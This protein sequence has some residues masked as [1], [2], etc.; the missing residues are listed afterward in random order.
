MSMAGGAYKVY[1]VGSSLAERGFA[2]LRHRHLLL[3]LVASDLRSRYRRSYLGVAW[4]MV[5]PIA[6]SFII[7]TVAIHVFQQPVET[8]VLYIITG[9]TVWELMAGAISGG[10]GS[11][12]QG[13]GYL[14][15]TRLPYILF[16]F[17]TVTFMSVNSFFS[18]VA[19]AV[20]IFVL[21][22]DAVSITWLYWPLILMMVYIF[23]V[24]LCLISAIANL[25]F[26]D[27]QHA[28]GLVV[29]LLWYLSPNIVVR[30]IYERPG[31]KQFTELNPFAS[32]LDM[33]RNVTLYHLPPDQHDLIV[34]G[35]Y[36][37]AAWTVATLWLRAE[38]RRLIYYM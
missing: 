16:P 28:I 33:F 23:A 22:R 35:A 19:A 24:P 1:A 26:R 13:E 29:F 34:W 11:I 12:Q 38:G 9:F 36:T 25:K 18:S 21:N 27:Y 5:W 31:L 15:Q 6:F 17:R 30:E 32:V 7:A 2:W 8:Y 37:I 14:R 20:M 4:A 3:H 10:V